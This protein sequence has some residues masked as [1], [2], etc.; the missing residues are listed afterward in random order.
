MQGQGVPTIGQGVRTIGEGVRAGATRTGQAMK[1]AGQR[2]SAP[3]RQG[4]RPVPRQEN[5]PMQNIAPKHSTKLY[6]V[7]LGAHDRLAQ[8]MTRSPGQ[9][10][11]S[12]PI[13][14]RYSY[15]CYG[16]HIVYQV[17]SLI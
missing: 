14:A 5:I 13:V 8:G 6:S 11:A 12:G 15:R 4:Y 3:W 16:R 2:M 9:N 7:A 10:S 17:K 1:E